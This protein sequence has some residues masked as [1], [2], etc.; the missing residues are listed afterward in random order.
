[1][2]KHIMCL[3]ILYQIVEAKHGKETPWLKRV[4]LSK[5]SYHTKKSNVKKTNERHNSNSDDLGQ[6]KNSI[7]EFKSSDEDASII[8]TICVNDLEKEVAQE[9]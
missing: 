1:M 8:N 7:F 3:L 9:C 2:K 5:R 4:H 6:I